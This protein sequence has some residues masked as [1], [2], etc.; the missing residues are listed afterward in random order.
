MP[1]ESNGTEASC[2]PRN[3]GELNS[4]HDES[5]VCISES[6]IR[7]YFLQMTISTVKRSSL[8]F[9]ASSYTVRQF[10]HLK[11]QMSQMPAFSA[12]GLV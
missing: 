3:N 10:E 12:A 4:Q 6:Q 7:A 2:W 9:C 5:S 1:T 8:S 11:L